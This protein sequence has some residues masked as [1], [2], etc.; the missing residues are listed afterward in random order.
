LKRNP[1]K[2][3]PNDSPSALP[4][5]PSGFPFVCNGGCRYGKP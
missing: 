2:T 5:A 3:A 4:V 1:T